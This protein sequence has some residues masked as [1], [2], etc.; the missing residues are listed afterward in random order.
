MTD[1]MLHKTT[2]SKDCFRL[3]QSASTLATRIQLKTFALYI[4]HSGRVSVSDPVETLMGINRFVSCVVGVL[5]IYQLS[6]ALSL[7]VLSSARASTAL[8]STTLAHRKAVA[9]AF[10]AF[11]GGLVVYQAGSSFI[12]DRLGSRSTTDIRL[13]G[14]LSIGSLPGEK[15]VYVLLIDLLDALIWNRSVERSFDSFDSFDPS[16]GRYH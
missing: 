6:P 10:V 4:R 5:S 14:C 15:P 13:P 11:G 1:S 8:W 2:E 12:V 3:S 7:A 9:L 16:H